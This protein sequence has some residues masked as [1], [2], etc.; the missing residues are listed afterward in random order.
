MFKETLLALPKDEVFEIFT[1]IAVNT[2]LACMRKRKDWYVLAPNYLDIQ[3][4]Y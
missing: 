4:E 3:K 1:V 2:K